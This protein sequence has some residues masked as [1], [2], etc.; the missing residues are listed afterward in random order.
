VPAC[1]FCGYESAEA[2]KFCPECGAA[3]APSG[4]EQRRVVTVLFC[5]VVGSTALGEVTDPEALRTLLARYFDRMK[6][7][8]ERHGGTVEKFI[9]DAV[10][11]V[12][13]APRAHEDDALRACRAALEMRKALPQLG[14]EGRIGVTT[15]EVVTGTEERLATG[16]AVNLAAR[17]QQAAPPGEVLLGE[18]TVALARGAV[19][20]EAVEPLALKGKSEPVSAFRLLAADEVPERRHE[21]EFVGR[22]QELAAIHEA[23]Q[24]VLSEQ[25]CELVTIAGEAGVGKSRLVAE[26]LPALHAPV[27]HGRCLPYGE[28][29]TY[30]PVVEVLRHINALPSD[31]AAA[32]SLRSLLGE[33]SVGTSAEEIAWSFRKLLEEQSPL[34][35]VFDDLQWGEES[36]LD[37]VE[38]VGLLSTAPILLVCLARPELTDRRPQWPVALRLE[39]LRETV[40]AE[41]I[42]ETIPAD[43]RERI[44]R[45]AGGNP[46]FLAEMLAMANKANGDLAVP[47]TLKALLAARLD[48]LDPAERRVLERGAVEGEIFHRGAV[49]ALGS[50]QAPVT[51]KLAALVRQELVRPDK[52][53]IV[54]D[55]GFRFRHLLIRDAAYDGL[56][57]SVRAQLHE[58]FAGWLEA[59]GEELVELNEILGYHL[60]QAWR[61]RQELGQAAD[62]Q[63][64]TA[65]RERLTAAERRA[66]GRQDFPAA[67]KFAERALALVPSGEVDAALEVD[68]LDASV[69]SG[70]AESGLA[71]VS[72]AVDRAAAGGDRTGELTIRG[73]QLIWEA[74]LGTAP[75]SDGRIDSFVQEALRELELAR[76]DLGLHHV[77][78]LAGYAALNRG[79]AEAAFAAIEKSG[80]YA[81]RLARHYAGWVTRQLI[82]A[83]ALGPTP[84]H[85]LLAWLEEQKAEGRRLGLRRV[86]ALATLGRAEALAMLTRF[87]E[88]QKLI[89]EVHYEWR[90][91][92]SLMDLAQS[93]DLAARVELLAENP[94][95]ADLYLA[96]ACVFVEARGLRGVLAGLAAQ[97]ALTL[98]ELDRLED[99]NEWVGR[100]PALAA[101]SMSTQISW[102]R[103]KAKILARQGRQEAAI[104]C[105]RQA[106][107]LAEGTD[108][109]TAQADANRD[110]AEALERAARMDD[111]VGS[112]R[113]AL[114][115]YERKG[116]QTMAERT[117]FRLTHLEDGRTVGEHDR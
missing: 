21:A 22:A 71:A 78:W 65:A 68:R 1:A 28:G 27:V 92:G 63:L 3:A 90:E 44:M 94:T 104:E 58:R 82:T 32:A 112:L 111:A 18:A 70:N 116:N 19:D 9:G 100:V 105:A 83:R 108:F 48:Q 17:L 110:L 99:A 96:E 41:L 93:A 14:V 66:I 16:D 49:Q 24:R 11:A 80:V 88:A 42:P 76:A 38:H 75:D 10:M 5:D 98:C 79:H 20:V 54:G 51:P 25:R 2:F 117:H 114:V 26:A 31:P 35:C 12:F 113:R 57:K 13:G 61:Y 37:L 81:R 102:L 109:L 46:L 43:L 4:Q 101:P 91:R 62:A 55:D 23:W 115:L 87:D 56:P 77:S 67:L 97:R 74:Q 72:A 8:I 33:A 45:A 69:L 60:E 86:E 85:E 59:R 7:I 15:G 39:P 84:V 103:A 34:V 30:W 89:A 40:A 6:E 52:A 36:F 47:P 73:V 95:K 50:D 29:I 107:E 64:A 106:V 53:Q